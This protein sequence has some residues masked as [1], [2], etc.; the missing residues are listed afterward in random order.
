MLCKIKV[1][2]H[3]LPRTIILSPL[4]PNGNRLHMN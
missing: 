3:E 2:W 1:V 4:G